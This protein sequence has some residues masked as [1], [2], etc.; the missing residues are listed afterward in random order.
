MTMITIIICNDPY[1]LSFTAV[2]NPNGQCDGNKTVISA[3]PDES[4]WSSCRDW[5][6][7]LTLWIPGNILNN[8]CQMRWC[9]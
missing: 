5:R 1:H 9:T 4:H 2:I 7:W 3:L 8:R 6:A